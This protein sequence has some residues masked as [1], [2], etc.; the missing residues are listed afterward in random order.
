MASLKLCS[1]F[2]RR[3][4]SKAFD[5][6]TKELPCEATCLVKYQFL[7]RENKV[8]V[9]VAVLEV[10]ELAFGEVELFELEGDHAEAL[11]HPAHLLTQGLEELL[12]LSQALGEV[13]ELS[14]Q[15]LGELEGVVGQQVEV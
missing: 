8:Q 5:W 2:K 12:D 15:K 4:F 1:F 10:G 11:S 3:N 14:E 6:L 9:D 13:G 7:P